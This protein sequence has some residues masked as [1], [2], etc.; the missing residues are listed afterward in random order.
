MYSN[1]LWPIV[2]QGLFSLRDESDGTRNV[3]IPQL[4]NNRARIGTI[5]AQWLTHREMNQME[6]EM[7]PYLNFQH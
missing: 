7:C 6:R 4:F 3:F 2:A 5:V 1:K